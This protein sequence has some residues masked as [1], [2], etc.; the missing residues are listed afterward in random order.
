[1]T[2]LVRY[3][4]CESVSRWPLSPEEAKRRSDQAATTR[5]QKALR[6]FRNGKDT[7]D[8]GKKMG[9]GEATICRW[10]DRERN[11]ERAEKHA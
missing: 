4:G 8:I 5:R 1:M 9:I 6:M 3:A 2:R 10:I 7:F 11:R